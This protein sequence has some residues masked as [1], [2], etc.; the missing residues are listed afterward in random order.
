MSDRKAFLIEAYFDDLED[1][2]DFLNQLN[3]DGRVDEALMLCCCYIEAIGS[4]RYHQSERKGKNFAKIL[5]EG[6]KNDLFSMVH[7]SKLLQV[8]KNKKLF[9]NTIEKI[10][11]III[12]YG[13][14]LQTQGDILA[15]LHSVLA[16]EQGAWFE[17]NLFKGTISA[18]TYDLVRN[19][20][21]HDVSAGTVTFSETTINGNPVPDLD[22][23]LL[24][25]ALRNVFEFVKS[26]SIGNNKWY[27][28]L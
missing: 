25:P 14:S 9:K 4:R 20:L 17:D 22:F 24:H 15:D 7:P 28:E 13:K 21:V 27:W 11:P 1:R 5:E 12:A 8:L 16:P 26:E 3:G 2:I 18:V 23:K 10:E 6:S 19:E